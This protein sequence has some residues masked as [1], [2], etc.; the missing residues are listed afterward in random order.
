VSV[1]SEPVFFVRE[2]NSGQDFAC[3]D[4]SKLNQT[5]FVN[6]I[7]LFPEIVQSIPEQLV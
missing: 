1:L 2:N 3:P 6:I 4:A 7:C 5:F